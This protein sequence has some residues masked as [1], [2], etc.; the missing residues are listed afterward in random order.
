METQSTATATAAAALAGVPPATL[1]GGDGGRCYPRW[2]MLNRRVYG[3]EDPS[4]SSS[5]AA[6]A[7]ITEAAA[8]SSDIHHV[9]R[10]SSFAAPPVPSHARL[11]FSPPLVSRPPSDPYL[12]VVAAHGDSVLLELCFEANCRRYVRDYF[13][14]SAGAGDPPRPSLSLS[15]LPNYWTKDDGDDRLLPQILDEKT[16][17]LVCRRRRGEDDVEELVVANL[18]AMNINHAVAEAELPV[19]RSG[20]LGVT[21]TPVIMINDG[22]K[23]TGSWETAM[24]V[25]LGDRFPCWW[26]SYYDN[27]LASKISSYFTSSDDGISFRNSATKPAAA[28]DNV[29]TKD[30]I[31]SGSSQP[32]RSTYDHSFAKSL[33]MLALSSPEEILAALQEIPGLSRDDLLKAYSMLCHD[34]GRRF[35]S[36]LGLPMSLRMPW[37]LMEIKASEA[38]SVCCAVHVEQIGYPRW[39]MLEHEVENHGNKRPIRRPLSILDVSTEAFSVSSGGQLLRVSFF[40]RAPPSSSRVCFDCF[41]HTD[42]RGVN[43][44][45]RLRILAAHAD[46]LLL[47]FCSSLSRGPRGN[48]YDARKTTGLL[49]RHGDDDGENDLVVADL[50]MVE[51]PRLKDAKLVILRSG[52]WSITRAPVVHFN[53]EPLPAWTTHAVIPVGDRPLCW[54]DLYRGVIVCDVFDEIPQ[55]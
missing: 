24:V 16:T 39:V 51:G 52:E 9:V 14:Y 22:N 50:A 47:D 43:D 31:I 11:H 25:P 21:R 32:A 3:N 38:C 2:V 46:S 55:L 48:I 27:Y 4:S 45:A 54:V 20:E 29:A 49:V 33:N 44:W 36:F 17:G 18:I 53:D 34:N 8:L 13:V 41:P 35:R 10:V 23:L 5:T 28:I 19:L 6:A 30:I 40:L 37:L 1:G 12:S 15:L 42:G 26:T 7:D